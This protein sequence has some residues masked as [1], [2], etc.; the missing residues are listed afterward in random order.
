MT[1]P[2]HLLPFL[3]AL[4]REGA[5]PIAWDGAKPDR[6]LP[7]KVAKRLEQMALIERRGRDF[8]PTQAGRMAVGRAI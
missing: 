8:V 2:A 4:C 6:T 3:E 1:T 7:E 5:K